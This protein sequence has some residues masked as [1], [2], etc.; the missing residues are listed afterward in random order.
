MRNACRPIS[1]LRTAYRHVLISSTANRLKTKQPFWDFHL[2]EEYKMTVCCVH[3]YNHSCK[4]QIWCF[5]LL[6][7]LVFDIPKSMF[8]L[9][10]AEM[11]PKR[12]ERS[13]RAKNLEFLQQ[14]QL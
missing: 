14:R 4:R 12:R 9:I 11:T 8:I 7:F 1:A 6:D 13:E 2:Y 10:N 3:M 5:S